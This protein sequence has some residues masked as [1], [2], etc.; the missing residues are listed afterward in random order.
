MSSFDYSYIFDDVLSTGVVSGI[1]SGI[2]SALIG[3]VTY[4]FTALALY[5]NAK[6]RG[7]NHPWLA[8]IPVADVWILG[9]LSDQYRYVVRGENKSKRKVL[10]ALSITTAVLCM[11]VIG[12]AVALAVQVVM[13]F[14]GNLSEQA[15]LQAIAGPLI[16]VICL[17]LPM[18][19]VAIAYMVI[20]YM[21]LYDVFTSCSPKNNVLFLLLSIF[22]G[23]HPF[24][25]FFIRKKEEG[26]PPRREPV[27]YIP[28]QA[29]WQPPQQN[30]QPPQSGDSG[31]AENT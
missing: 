23:I 24:I 30:W 31:N 14:A 27:S 9:S 12:C 3:I 19:G 2:P 18:V 26:M 16:G 20:S 29:G 8:W 4:V 25:V 5:T 17:C 28:P 6:R 13:A 22:L 10:L 7:I 21:A 1:L 11:A 15:I